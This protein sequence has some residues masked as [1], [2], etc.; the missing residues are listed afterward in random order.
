MLIAAQNS[1]FK[2]AG[3]DKKDE[4]NDEKG[5]QGEKAEG[6]EHT[7]DRRQAGPPGPQDPAHP[8]DKGGFEQAATTAPEG[9][10][11]AEHQRKGGAS[12]ATKQI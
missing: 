12:D 7:E 2:N 4:G 10:E 6:K 1:P 3:E 8:G 11:K 5:V 9:T